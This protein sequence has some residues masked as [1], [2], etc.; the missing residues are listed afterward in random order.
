MAAQIIGGCGVAAF[1]AAIVML[2]LVVRPALGGSTPHGWP[3]WATCTPDQIREQLLEDQ[4]ADR[5]CVLAR[6]AARKMYG[7]RHAI[8]FLLGGIG[9]L[10]LAAVTGLALAA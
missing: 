2:L 7:I 1:C 6:L 10:A 4:R 8:H 9:C 3:H 5:L